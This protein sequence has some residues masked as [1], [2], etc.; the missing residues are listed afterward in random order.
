VL[1]VSRKADRDKNQAILFNGE[2][3]EDSDCITLLGVTLNRSLDYADHVLSLARKASQA[4]GALSRARHHLSE[5]ARANVYRSVIRPI[6][7]YSSPVWASAPDYA[8]NALDRIQKYSQRLFPSIPMD[9]LAHRRLVSDMAVFHACIHRFVPSA[10]QALTPPAAV[11]QCSTRLA[12]QA[13]SLSVA[14]PA[15]KTTRHSKS[16]FARCSATWNSLPSHIAEAADPKNFKRL[17]HRH[18]QPKRNL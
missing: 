1:T 16:Y 18:F 3:L 17:L 8:L 4:Y 7:E 6:M 2:P 10:L 12:S 13:H 9:S 11:Y 5:S 15:S 14:S